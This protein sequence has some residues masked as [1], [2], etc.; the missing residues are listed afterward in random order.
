MAIYYDIQPYNSLTF[1]MGKLVHREM[2]SL[3]SQEHT[4]KGQEGL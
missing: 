1:H 2:N 4:V 3:V